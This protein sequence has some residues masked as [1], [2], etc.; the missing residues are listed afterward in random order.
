MALAPTP[1]PYLFTVEEY[2][3]FER[4]SEERHEYLDG[5]IYAMAGSASP[6]AMA[7]EREDHGT[8]CTNL[9]GPC[10]RPTCWWRKADRSSATMTA[11]RPG[12]GKGRTSK[13]EAPT[14]T[15][16]ASTARCRWSTCTSVSCSPTKQIR[17]NVDMDN[18]DEMPFQ[19]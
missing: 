18:A 3:A 11:P 10:S 6:Q 9:G 17:E 1:Q 14:C 12:E 15:W 8:I 19:Q 16:T 2:L 5:V 13:A 7:G 4:A